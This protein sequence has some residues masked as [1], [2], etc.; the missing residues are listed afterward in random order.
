MSFPQVT[1]SARQRGL[2]IGVFHL[3]GV[4]PKAIEPHLLDCHSY[5]WQL[6]SL[7]VV[8]AYGQVAKPHRSYR[9]SDGLSSGNH[10]PATCRFACNCRSQRRV[11]RRRHGS[12]LCRVGANR[13]REVRTY[14]LSSRSRLAVQRCIDSLQFTNMLIINIFIY[15]DILAAPKVLSSLRSH[16]P[17][18]T[19]T[20]V[21]TRP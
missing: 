7:H 15:A 17:K 2:E 11:Q 9:H 1:T 6:G 8:F 10:G 12:Y 4:L 21:Y 14:S 5:R 3:I 20:W 18:A 19:T 13:R 16:I